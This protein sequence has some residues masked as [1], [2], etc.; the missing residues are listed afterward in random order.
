M[1][2][3]IALTKRQLATIDEEDWDKI[4][5]FS[6][7]AAPHTSGGYYAAA[8]PELD[9]PTR[10]RTVYMHRIILDADEG[11]YVDHINH[12]TLDNRKAN[13]RI[14]TNKQNIENRRGANSNSVTGIRGVTIHKCKPSGLMYSANVSVGGVHRAKYF[15]YTPEGLTQAATAVIQM[16]T[17][18]MTHS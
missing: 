17:E 6:W 7:F 14:V 18:L 15:P 10:L 8:H 1:Q 4:S 16:R 9:M 5:L 11:Q 3:Q 13:L 12:D 2:M